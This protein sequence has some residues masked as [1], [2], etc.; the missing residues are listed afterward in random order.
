MT[1]APSPTETVQS[2]ID[3]SSLAQSQTMINFHLHTNKVNINASL[4]LVTAL[5]G[6]ICVFGAPST[7]AIFLYYFYLEAR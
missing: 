4:T 5:V 2:I 6:G 3:C 7:R 1:P